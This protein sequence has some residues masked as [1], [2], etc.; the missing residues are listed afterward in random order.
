MSFK[1]SRTF[2][3]VWLCIIMIMTSMFS[4]AV[5]IYAAVSEGKLIDDIFTDKAMYN[6]GD[7]VNVMI[8]LTNRTNAAIQ[9][10]VVLQAMH[11]NQK[12]G[13]VVTAD[14]HG[15]SFGSTILTLQWE[16]PAEDFKGYLLEVSI[17]DAEGKLLDNGTVGVDVSSRWNK[18]PRYGYLHD[19]GNDVDTAEKIKKMTK[20]HLN[21]I[22]YYDW[23]YLHHKPLAEGIT[24]ENPGVWEDW[25]GRK[26]YGKTV[27]DYIA[28]AKN[29][30][31]ANLAYNMIYAGTDTFFVDQDGNPTEA[32][33]W[34]VFFH[35]DN[36]RGD[37]GFFN[38]QFYFTMGNSPSGNGRLYFVNPLDENWQQHIFT[39]QNKVFEV[40][41][42]DGWHGDTV[43][44]WGDMVTK[45]GGPLGYE[46]DGTPIYS[47]LKT[48]TAFLNA[49]KEAL[50]DKY[51]TFNPV[52]AK[53]I[54][55]A[56]VS[57]VDSLYTEFW[58]WDYNRHGE[59]Y[60][61]YAS[62]VRE[63]EDSNKDSGGKSLTV[64]AYINY[65]ASDGFM[66]TPAV[67]LADI[68]A[69]AAGGSRL[70]IGN[71]D[72][73]LHKEYY[74]DDKIP[75]SDTLKVR[76][77]N[78]YDFIVAYENILRDGQETTDN[79]VIVD[80]YNSSR[81]GA[82]NTIWTYTRKDNNNQI[83]HLINLLGTDNKWRDE[84]KLKSVPTKVQNI[85]VKYYYSG[86][87]NSVYIAS[88]DREECRTENLEFTKG[89]DVNG[90]YVEFI[91]PS[92][93]YWDM[94]YMNADAPTDLSRDKA[95]SSEY[96]L[97]FEAE[98]YYTGNKA[99]GQADLQPGENISIQMP[100]NF[101]K[102]TYN[103]SVVSCGNR[104]QLDVSVDGKGVGSI[105]RTGTGFGMN[106]MTTDSV[107][108]L[109]IALETGNVLEIQDSGSIG[110]GYG[111][112][113]KV[114]LTL[115]EKYKEDQKENSDPYV[116]PKNMLYKVEGEDGKT[117]AL[118]TLDNHPERGIYGNASNHALIKNIGLN[119]GYVELTLP[120]EVEA[121]N[122]D[123]VFSY[124]S[125]TDGKVNIWVNGE[126]RTLDYTATDRSWRF[127]A[128]TIA[129]RD[130]SI[131]PG[132]VIKI[133]DALDNCWIWMDY[134]YLVSPNT[135]EAVIDTSLLEEAIG[136]AEGLNLSLY[137]EGEAK[138][139]FKAA[140]GAAK[141]VQ[142]APTSQEEVNDALNTL[143]GSMNLL[144]AT[145][146][147]SEIVRIEAEDGILTAAGGSPGIY[148]NDRA[149]NGQ[150]V[151]DIGLKQ[152]Y[153]ELS[154]PENIEEGVYALRL[155]YSSGTTGKVSVTINGTV[156]KV[157][158]YM[159]TDGWEFKPDNFIDINGVALKGGDTIK[160]H[161][162][163]ADCYIWLD[164]IALSAAPIIV[165]VHT[166]ELEKVIAEAKQLDLALYTD[167][168]GKD[169][170]NKALEAAETVLRT[171]NSQE[172][173]NSAAELLRNA[174]SMLKQSVEFIEVAKIEAE[175]GV[176]TENG[177]NPGVYDNVKA[178]NGQFV[179]DIGLNQGYVELIVPAHVQEGTYM[180]RLAYSSGTDGQV[181][182]T[183]NNNVQKISNYLSTGGWE[184]KPD[185]YIELSR[186]ELKAGD[187]IKI[188]DALDNCWIWLDYAAILKQKE[189]RILE[190]VK[191]N[192]ERINIVRGKTSQVTVTAAYSDLTTVNVTNEVDYSFSVNGIAS[193]SA[194]GLVTGVKEG[195][196]TLRAEYDGMTVLS[197]VIVTG[198]A[199]SS[200]GS[201]GG[202]NSGKT[203]ATQ[204]P[205]TPNVQVPA[206]PEVSQT[207]VAPAAPKA[208]TIFLVNGVAS[209]DGANLPL[210][211]K[212]YIQH[213]RT[214]V[215]VRDMATLLN[216]ESK[217]IIWD[218]KS[219]SIVIKTSDKEVKLIIGQKYALVNGEKVDIDTAPEV[220]DGRTVLPIGHVARILGMKVSFDPVTK[221][222]TFTIE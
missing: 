187:T 40:F 33:Q 188:H 153:V 216:V 61:T 194:S 189:P 186:I 170:F 147:F 157:A 90:N 131:N 74:P 107:V 111:W 144:K 149:S 156:E 35:P 53:G 180:L 44:D 32:D 174:I 60:D 65:G 97:V 63:V 137:A 161:D 198:E 26:I 17:Y 209:S 105:L 11:L 54:E 220:K 109:P 5:P 177:G 96:Q 20:Y 38:R 115:I 219:K 125:G 178:S 55:Y 122:Y 124:S 214:M 211:V 205:V 175:D 13:D 1:K 202:S 176:L 127:K 130:I 86:D 183:V 27:Q 88:P 128:N 71:G 200:G 89:S 207:S 142:N 139:T 69:F 135:Y 68:A 41:D 16:A 91:V 75:M 64:K 73:M 58:P 126:Q 208:V 94:I 15:S 158:N 66:N 102:G 159:T 56:N 217:N 181:S 7:I 145:L 2:I 222:A 123:L 82:S 28:T 121:A 101:I 146:E 79:K 104:T 154:I 197:E 92:L 203:T 134:I 179:H 103:V 184:F 150:F 14:Y 47:I 72:S 31:M 218:A 155:A 164:Y 106:E 110:S 46:E 100:G 162:A 138:D 78:L 152:G 62:L 70:T 120:E 166:L 18:F 9:G 4:G 93:E 21:V 36:E 12:V 45:D 206:I 83:L 136:E 173:V 25:A 148:T 116:Y 59:L 168:T 34:T 22:E 182:V 201:G 42:F 99:E 199:A 213:G 129:I 30:N 95:A 141:A 52:G 39:E 185:N 167:E 8:E 80:G 85:P 171:P 119:Q 172:A 112:V 204:N 212:P 6:P 19:F 49:A 113:D 143:Q 51:L 192:P 81:N 169:A 37:T 10:K 24:K 165:P 193:V 117:T 132:D 215:G 160:I 77:R 108:E 196:T 195:T 190:A 133:Q 23:H 43:G 140:L 29:A 84:Y 221:Q 3:S 48:Y 76:Q 50:G 151:H 87:V 114:I 210:L 191:I 118:P 67:M 57:K 163:L 98:D